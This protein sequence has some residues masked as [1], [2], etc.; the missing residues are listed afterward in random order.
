MTITITTN[1]PTT[2]PLC[3]SLLVKKILIATIQQIDEKINLIARPLSFSTEE[4]ATLFRAKYPVEESDPDFYKYVYYRRKKC[5]LK[6]IQSLLT[7]NNAFLIQ[8]ILIDNYLCEF[9]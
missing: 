7:P 8:R 3:C 6:H 4:S 5:L 1:Q 9:E 2:D